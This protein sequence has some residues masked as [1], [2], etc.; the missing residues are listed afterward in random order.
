[1]NRRMMALGLMLGSAIALSGCATAVVGSLTVSQI[2]TIAGAASTATTGRGL[3]DHALSA[4]TGRDCRLLEGIF[5]QNRHICEEPGSSATEDDF[6]GFVV[7]IMGPR[8]EEV[9]EEPVGDPV[10]LYAGLAT[11]YRP[12]LTRQERRTGSAPV[13][14]GL[15]DAGEMPTILEWASMQPAPALTT[16]NLSTD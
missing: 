13:P 3:Q 14:F 9:T 5:R 8:E 10:V 1:M 12:S 7:M 6:K 4:V 11:E 15:A 2:S 16:A